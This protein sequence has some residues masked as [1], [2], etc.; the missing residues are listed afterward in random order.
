MVENWVRTL[1]DTSFHDRQCA[2]HPD[3]STSFLCMDCEVALCQQCLEEHSFFYHQDTETSDRGYLRVYRCMLH[4]V[5]RCENVEDFGLDMQGVQKYMS[6]EKEAIYLRP[7]PAPR[8]DRPVS[9]KP[10]SGRCGRELRSPWTYCSLA[11]KIFAESPGP[12]VDMCQ[13]TTIRY[14]RT[15]RK[16]ANPRRSIL[17]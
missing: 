10:C 1:I 12:S 6:N 16:Q 7:R 14:R 8:I 15:G 13:K 17:G 4:D 11:C 3:V 5:V 9:S 2:L